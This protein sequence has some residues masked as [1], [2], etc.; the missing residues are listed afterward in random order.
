MSTSTLSATSAPRWALFAPLGIAF[1][2]AV[3][4]GIYTEN[5]HLIGGAAVAAVLALGVRLAFMA[6]RASH[7]RAERL[8]IW[9]EGRPAQARVRSIRTNGGL[10]GHPR[11]DFELEV[12]GPV[13]YRAHVTA[14]VSKLAVPRIQPGSTIEVRIDPRDPA[15]VVIAE[16]LTPY[17]YRS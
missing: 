11:V 1:W 17:G 10:N 5:E 16:D 13:P 3:G 2:L 7:E 4:L 9:L 12:H 14:L 6:K 8:R 15:H